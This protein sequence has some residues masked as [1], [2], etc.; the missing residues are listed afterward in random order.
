[1]RYG[2]DSTRFKDLF[3]KLTEDYKI[4][5]KY[6]LNRLSIFIKI[7]SKVKQ[8][9]NRKTIKNKYINEFILRK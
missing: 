2:G 1:M 3:L 7:F 4:A 9:L 6:K 5:R 8:L